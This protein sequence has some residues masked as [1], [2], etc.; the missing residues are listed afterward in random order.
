MN[1]N[2]REGLLVWLHTKISGK[3]ASLKGS[4]TAR[5]TSAIKVYFKEFK[6]EDLAKEL[7]KTDTKIKN[8]EKR[9]YALKESRQNT[10]QTICHRCEI[11]FPQYGPSPSLKDGQDIIEYVRDRCNIVAEDRDPL[12]YNGTILER[13]VNGKTKIHVQAPGNAMKTFLQTWFYTELKRLQELETFRSETIPEIM[14]LE[15]ISDARKIVK[16]VKARVKQK[17]E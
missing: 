13:Y 15:E 7:R 16:D 10:F 6:I 3:V 4:M 2:Q 1:Q 14:L 9:I 8:L 11:Q 17:S 5:L 12:R